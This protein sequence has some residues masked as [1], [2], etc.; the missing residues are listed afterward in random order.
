MRLRLLPRAL[1]RQHRRASLVA[2][3]IGLALLAMPLVWLGSPSD[4][5]TARP[6]MIL[7]RVWLDRYPDEARTE[8]HLFYWSSSGLGVYQ[9]GSAYRGSFDVFDFR[10][11]G[12]ELDLAFLQDDE[13]ASIRFSVEACDVAPFDLC[14]TLAQSPRGPRRYFS[15]SDHR[16]AERA[17]PGGLLR[18][19]RAATR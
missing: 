17:L 2:L 16:A 19:A 11:S 18:R 13:R 15:W 1:W 7:D 10:R 4:E 8:I 3:A 6:H 12:H 5:P 9:R 14:L